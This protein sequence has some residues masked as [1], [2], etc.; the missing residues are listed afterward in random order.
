MNYDLYYFP[1]WICCLL[2]FNLIV[3][4]QCTGVAAF[5]T[6]RLLPKNRSQV[7]TKKTPV[8]IE[9]NLIR[10]TSA[11]ALHSQ[12]GQ[13]DIM[14]K[15]DAWSILDMIHVFMHYGINNRRRLRSGLNFSIQGMSNGIG[16]N[17]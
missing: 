4:Y 9:R 7:N 10:S 1:C 8:L 16:I 14:R 13:P 11:P 15:E 2:F 3:A 5:P 6:T 17:T 12:P